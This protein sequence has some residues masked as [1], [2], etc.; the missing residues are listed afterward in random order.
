MTIKRYEQD[1]D[2]ALI[3]VEK[4]A[5]MKYEDHAS[6]VARLNEQVRALSVAY[7][8]MTYVLINEGIQ[9][10]DPKPAEVDTF[11][12]EVGAR[13]VDAFGIYH[14]FSEK[15]LIQAEAKKYAAR[16]RAGEVQP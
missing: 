11:M 13:A 4:G 12:N 5:L 1:Y 16:I 8:R 14:N 9:V 3:E 7:E 2:G 15:Q 6:E 10:P